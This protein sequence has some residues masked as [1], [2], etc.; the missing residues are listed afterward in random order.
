MSVFIG[1]PVNAETQTEACVGGGIVCAIID[2]VPY[3][4]T[5]ANNIYEKVTPHRTNPRS[6]TYTATLTGDGDT[7]EH[8]LVF[9][10]DRAVVTVRGEFQ[11]F[12]LMRLIS[13]VYYV[14]VDIQVPRG[15]LMY[16]HVSGVGGGY[17]PK[18][19][20][21]T[22]HS[23][24]PI[25]GYWSESLFWNGHETIVETGLPTSEDYERDH[26]KALEWF[27]RETGAANFVPRANW[28]EWTNV[29]FSEQ[30]RM[31]MMR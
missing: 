22:I 21:L 1:T 8:E 13:S 11:A 2:G 14:T 25:S 18:G 19:V 31:G 28:D 17:V 3:A 6:V 4:E 12:A 16:V 5:H 7:G 30:F 24:W 10:N 20:P 23:K 15:D 29:R 27:H 9:Y 26:A